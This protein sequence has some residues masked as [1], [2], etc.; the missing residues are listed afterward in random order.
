MAKPARS[1][2]THRREELAPAKAPIL[3]GVIVVVFATSLFALITNLL[4]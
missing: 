4:G 1:S 2:R 3:L